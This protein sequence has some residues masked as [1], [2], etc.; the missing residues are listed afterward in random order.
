MIEVLNE[1]ALSE[2]SYDMQGNNSPSV[3]TRNNYHMHIT[4]SIASA[5]VRADNDFGEGLLTP[6]AADILL[7]DFETDLYKVLNGEAADGITLNGVVSAYRPPMLKLN[8]SSFVSDLKSKFDVIY[9][10][11]K[12]IEKSNK[13]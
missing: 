13:K 5:L 9:K 2:M 12:A 6:N 11:A 7:K 10:E 1:M 4:S 3:E 8:E